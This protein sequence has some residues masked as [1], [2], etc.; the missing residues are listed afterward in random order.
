MQKLSGHF[1][2]QWPRMNTQR[3]IKLGKLD[4]F[5]RLSFLDLLKTFINKLERFSHNLIENKKEQG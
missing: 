5:T 2:K 1:P 3:E 4:S